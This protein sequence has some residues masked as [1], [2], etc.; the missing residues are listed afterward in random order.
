MS[1]D[2]KVLSEVLA[3]VHVGDI[4][5]YDILSKSIGRD[6]RTIARGILD[7]A[8]KKVLNDR[9]IV[10]GTVRG[11]GLRR[12]TDEETVD[13]GEQTLASVRGATRRGMRRITAVDFDSLPNEKKILHNV[14]ASLF[15]TL[16]HFSRA[17]SVK[18]LSENASSQTGQLPVA[19]TL[20]ILSSR[21]GTEA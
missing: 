8:R 2:A 11:A 5:T 14:Y 16:S 10:F 4:V 18:A 12:L 1:I 21:H 7:T 6:V 9:Q 19:K 3:K 15:G 17:K 13:T 20:E